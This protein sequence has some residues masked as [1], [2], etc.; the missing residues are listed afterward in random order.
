MTAATQVSIALALLP[1]SLQH[2]ADR[3]PA[4]LWDPETA[5]A[6]W[7]NV[8]AARLLDAPDDAAFKPLGHAAFSREMK[9][10]R[11]NA[12][13]HMM[14]LQTRRSPG[15]FPVSME[16]VETASG[17][18]LIGAVGMRE[19]AKAPAA[20][21]ALMAFAAALLEDG[22]RFLLYGADKAM[23]AAGPTAL[24]TDVHAGRHREAIFEAGVK[25]G[26]PAPFV[27][28]DGETK[29]SGNLHL[30]ADGGDG[31]RLVMISEIET[32]SAPSLPEPPLPATQSPS[33]TPALLP[34]STGPLPARISFTLDDGGKLTSLSQSFSTLL[35]DSAEILKGSAFEM[36]FTPD[37]AQEVKS[38]IASR[39]TWT[40][41]RRTIAVTGGR[42]ANVV[43][44]GLPV[45]RGP[46][47][48][49]G[50]R[51]FGVLEG[52]SPGTDAE[53]PEP[54]F[55][56]IAATAPECSEP[57]GAPEPS[58]DRNETFAVTGEL[59]FGDIEAQQPQ[60]TEAV[61]QST[62][63]VAEPTSAT[64]TNVVQ[65]RSV[66]WR[67][68]TGDLDEREAAAFRRIARTIETAVET[69]TNGAGKE[70][71][72]AAPVSDEREQQ[73]ERP[74]S[75]AAE[76]PFIPAVAPE[77]LRDTPQPEY[78]PH[79]APE[80]HPAGRVHEDATP[81]DHVSLLERLPLG[82]AIL[83]DGDITFANRAFFDLLGY[84]DLEHLKKVGGVGAIFPSNALPG[85]DQG[86]T[87][88]FG[89]RT[90]KAI[91]HDGSELAVSA[92]LQSIQ[93]GGETCLLLSLRDTI[94]AA[95]DGQQYQALERQVAEQ[96]AIIEAAGDGV[97]IL[98]GRG[99]VDSL[100]PRAE[101]LLGQ[102]IHTAAGMTFA[103][104]FARASRTA[105]SQHFDVFKA[106]DR[107]TDRLGCE[108]KAHTAQGG[109][110]PLRV[111]FAEIGGSDTARYCAV[112]RDLTSFKDAEAALT[113]AKRK[114]EDASAHKSDFVAKISHEMRTP[115][116]A[117]IGFSEVMMEERFG[118]V[119][120]PRYHEYVKDIHRGGAHLL[121]L[122]NDLLDLSKIEAG[123]LELSFTSVNL[124]D[125]VQQ[126]V[127][128]MQP[129]ANRDRIIIRTSLPAN[130][131]PIVADSK[132]IRQIALNILS[133]AV[134]YTRPGGQVIVSTR[135]DQNGE[136]T[137][138]I[139]DTGIGM[140]ETEVKTAL[141]PF[142]Q[143]GTAKPDR[144]GTGLGLPLTKAL[145]EANR[146]L[147]AIESAVNSGTTIRVTFPV[148]RVLAE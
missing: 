66:A 79:I 73:A 9:K 81:D 39:D 60:K 91:R 114:A 99:H 56:G 75:R 8:A 44:S 146:A 126:C 133:N 119:G 80:K 84:G 93:W 24:E 68:E 92:R 89:R 134:K 127:S 32:L 100:N 57:A 65:L 48:F 41:L 33:G 88:G 31:A 110:R 109:E 61:Q 96:Q 82:L 35:G 25:N 69:S 129:E 58:K 123:K 136:V 30:M 105:V 19:D 49:A 21:D 16:T 50:Y 40:G 141:E 143:L 137:L 67:E 130:V 26:M 101:A 115:L 72:E 20:S 147:F 128:I 2:T 107:P 23:V 12:P 135:L 121:S 132:S 27:H 71:S 54:A 112:L 4:W 116:N 113:D 145:V 138:T 10:A 76:S 124:N 103:D 11:V 74:R 52:V 140:S 22:F 1:F 83:Q 36:L 14:R 104:L 5:D 64:Q 62:A 98:D 131:P 142:R 120:N 13:L 77:M 90:L 78:E 59:P 85:A 106:E 7:L 148:T 37:E 122:I 15:P 34:D 46:S 6:V 18:V 55:A 29:I 108:V 144:A 86:R 43:F 118:P 3:R 95:G 87:D 45:F 53:E 111:F 94:P 42:S 139:S 97:L 47:D 70:A 102:T 28:D 117:I 38:L 17:R 63:P 51:G 125:V